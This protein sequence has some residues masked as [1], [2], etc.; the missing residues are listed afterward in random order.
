[1]PSDA[2]QRGTDAHELAEW[3][4]STTPYSARPLTSES[5]VFLTLMGDADEWLVEMVAGYVNY[6]ATIPGEQNYETRALI[7]SDCWGTAD[8]VSYDPDTL[9]L[10]IVDL[11]T[12]QGRVDAENNTQLLLYALG[13]YRGMLLAQYEFNKFVLTIVQPSLEHVSTWEINLDILEEFSVQY[14]ESVRRIKEEPESYEISETTCQW[15]PAKIVCPAFKTQVDE[16]ARLD[17]SGAVAADALAQW[18]DRLPLLKSL[19]KTVE[20]QA[21]LRMKNFEE[22]PGYWL[23][24]PHQTR[25]FNLDKL[26]S[27]AKSYGLMNVL[28]P[29]V[30]LT[31]AAAKK[32][33]LSDN[34][35]AKLDSAVEVK[36]GE[37]SIMKQK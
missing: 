25:S 7:D 10:H 22:I 27:L 9:T 14:D 19:I 31:P 8:C 13:I 21:K 24:A 18:L 16:L 20:E 5:P 3:A 12:G 15:C 11:K 32:L 35:K 29:R 37:P 17:F 23:S 34:L 6:L 1:M 36:L 4:L 33:G 28:L 26:T 30:P 2:A